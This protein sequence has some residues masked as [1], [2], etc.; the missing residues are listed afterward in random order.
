[1]QYVQLYALEQGATGNSG[2]KEIDLYTQEPIKITK[3]VLSVDDITQN[4][5]SFS[6]TFRVPHTTI[7]GKF[8]KSVF[9][10]NSL[11]FDATRRTAAYILIDGATF[12]YGNIQLM[13]IFRNDS[14]GKIEYEITFLGA[15][16]AFATEIGPR[17][18][19]VI[20]LSDLS[21]ELTYQ[22]ITASWTAPGLKNG[23]VIYPLAEYGYSY[24]GNTADQ[25]TLAV[26]DGSLAPKGFTDSNNPLIA[27][28]FRPA[29]RVKTIWDRIF[30]GTNYTYTS[31]FVDNILQQLYTMS[32]NYSSPLVFP[33]LSFEANL[34]D[35][36]GKFQKGN[37][38]NNAPFKI[39][40]GNATKNFANA[41]LPIEQQYK[42]PVSNLTYNFSIN[43]RGKIGQRNASDPL[44][45]QLQM[46]VFRNGVLVLTDSRTVQPQL[47]STERIALQL[48]LYGV[49]RETRDFRIGGGSGG[50]AIPTFT[51][52]NLQK[53][54]IVEF[55]VQSIAS[56]YRYFSPVSGVIS[57]SIPSVRT[58]DP[59]GFL[60]QQYKQLEFIKALNDRFKLVW[61]PDKNNPNN[62]LIEPYNDWVLGGE[63]KDWTD[64]LNENNDIAIQPLFY[65]QPR[66]L[67]FKDSEEGD[68][69]NFSYQQ[70]WKETF[71]QYNTDSGI[72]L[73]TN[74]KE[75]KSLFAPLP[76]APIANSKKFLI[77]HFAKDTETQRQPILIKPRIGYVQTGIDTGGITWY[78]NDDNG[79]PQP[80]TTYPLY[81]SF[82]TYP[83]DATSFDLNWLN[84]PQFW[85]TADLG[86]DGRT[87]S[88]AFNNYWQNWWD[89]IYD[90]YS[91][92][93]EATFALDVEDVQ[94]LSFNDKIFVKDSWWLVLEIKDF[95][96]N[97]KNNVRVKL[98]KLGNLGINIIGSPTSGQNRYVQSG[99][100]YGQLLCDACCCLYYSI[101]VYTDGATF[102][103]S[104]TV[105]Y[106][107]AGT[108]P[109][110]DG[111]YFDGADVYV[112]SFG[113][114]VSVGSCASCECVPL[115]LDEF[116]S[117][118]AADSFCQACCCDVATLTAFADASSLE[119]AT[120]AFQ[121]ALGTPWTPGIWLKQTGE[122]NAVQIG[123]DG[124]TI[125]AV[126]ACNQC[127]CN[128]LEDE[129]VVPIGTDFQSACCID[130][131]DSF[132]VQTI[133][134]NNAIL[135]SSTL[136][137]FDPYEQFPIGGT[138]TVY[139]S[140]GYEYV[141]VQ[142]ATGIASGLC[143]PTGCTGRS[144]VVPFNINT[145][146]TGGT[147]SIG[148]TYY[149]SFDN[150]NFYYNGSNT[151]SGVYFDNTYYPTYATGSYFQYQFTGGS[152][153]S[154]E[155]NFYK[156]AVLYLTDTVVL[157]ASYISPNLGPVGS[158]SW[159]VEVIASFPPS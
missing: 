94:N 101:P 106:D 58:V 111:Y 28:Q 33:D 134:T 100:C 110:N 149:I 82:N 32:S 126:A 34:S 132:G 7:N 120:R 71:G 156:N 60:P 49:G 148:S 150:E 6:R 125:V 80:Q 23:D 14:T 1:M 146:G 155:V 102:A 91:R 152:G 52:V 121:D 87:N 12:D 18:M 92:L 95:V 10:V 112:V 37:D 62:F 138:G 133:S 47:N 147:G 26:Y 25:S 20:D 57:L 153:G 69:Y 124:T 88:T 130:A 44:N 38:I 140:D 11:D 79:V 97:A 39:A 16:S 61:E 76:I 115:L 107:L 158:D 70:Q 43:L 75:I 135:T 4:K 116:N 46:R 8:F 65:T 129:F 50:T 143:A 137:Y 108:I 40:I 144:E 67:I 66:E 84:P 53:G 13:S 98:L 78:F 29:I 157:P 74:K 41:W 86:F 118:C 127:I 24:T 81:S 19:S 113:N 154:T 145:G 99:I 151:D 123:A 114:L 142:G 89:A 72:E 36:S 17:D 136:F 63:Q 77:P 128:P 93:M 64:K 51:G 9:N 85:D 55:Y 90:P 45:L 122:N 42:V 35:T 73:I 27:D 131:P 104:G 117:V 105:T 109:A 22:N 96:L 5:S 2:Y 31:S 59:S 21:H 56:V 48:I 159:N 30:A 141:E 15:T 103:T 54:D 83:I 139:A 119:L 3:S 68:L